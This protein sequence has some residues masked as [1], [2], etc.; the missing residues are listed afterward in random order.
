[1]I[2]L[3]AT[4]VIVSGGKAIRG[5]QS[6]GI[7]AGQPDLIEAAALNN[8]PLQAIGRP[9]KVG[10]EEIAG[11]VVAVERFFAMD[12]QDQLAEWRSW[13]EQIA[14]AASGR[15]GIRAEVVEGHPDYG[16]P[17]LA[18]KAVL[19]FEGG[20]PAADA[21]NEHLRAG[22]PAIQPLRQGDYLIFNPMTLMPGEAE[23][24]ADRLREALA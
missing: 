14:R 17:P 2:A 5:P 13:S 21:L 4:G 15:S 24:I 9:M 23:V 12:E 11:L 3:G 18:P 7:L 22:E 19:R 8:N 1:L 20:A 10:K 16:R 6:S